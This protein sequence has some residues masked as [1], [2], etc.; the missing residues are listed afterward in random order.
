M[1]AEGK[2]KKTKKAATNSKGRGVRIDE[3]I[4]T[5]A[6]V[7]L[8]MGHTVSFVCSEL[9]LKDSTVRTW[10]KALKD[11]DKF[12]EFRD[13]ILNKRRNEYLLKALDAEGESLDILCKKLE[14]AK[15]CEEKRG[16]LI[17]RVL[18]DKT[19]NNLSDTEVKKELG[20][21]MPEPLGDVIRAFSVLTEKVALM[22]GKPTANV[23]ISTKKF[24]DL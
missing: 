9:G 8:G 18:L 1:G 23:E 11:D 5:K 7:M 6:Q 20:I 22:S 2:K 15:I 13:N 21:L 14:N 4:K 16:E 24:E 12:V 17:E 3:R 19:K 10:E